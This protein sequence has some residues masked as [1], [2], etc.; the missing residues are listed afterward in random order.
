MND[1]FKSPQIYT[2]PHLPTSFIGLL[3][4][5]DGPVLQAGIE[6]VVHAEDDRAGEH[7]TGRPAAHQGA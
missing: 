4:Q 7:H 2:N 3:L 1:H 6:A 5:T